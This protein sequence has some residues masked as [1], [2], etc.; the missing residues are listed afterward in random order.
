MRSLEEP[1]APRGRGLLWILLVLAM[2]GGAAAWYATTRVASPASSANPTGGPSADATPS[3][4]NDA[5]S[6]TERN[7]PES[8]GIAPRPKASRPIQNARAAPTPAAPATAR[9]EF[10]V[11]SDVPGA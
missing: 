9:R 2:L 10:R 1:E 3:S 6:A 5:T 7:T 11:T 8:D 4:G